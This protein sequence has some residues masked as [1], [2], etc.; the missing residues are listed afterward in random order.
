MSTSAPPHPAT[1]DEAEAGDHTTGSAKPHTLAQSLAHRV[2]AAAGWR[3]VG[4]APKE[5]KYVLIAAPHTTN[6]DLVLLLLASIEYGVWPNW[7]GK[8]TLFKPPFGPLMR[9]L[10]GIAVD[11]RARHNMVDHL[12]S[13]FREREKLIL[14]V[15]PEGTRSAA[16]H[17]K[18]GFYHI[19][20]AAKVPICLGYL[21]FPTKRAAL[22]PMMM[23]TGNI[24]ADMEVIRA[25]YAD[26]RGMYPQDQGPVRLASED[27][28]TN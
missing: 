5:A 4:E 3:I 27:P 6:W 9:A 20:V 16:P 13:L 22:G 25:F 1:R 23:P 15:P 19:A 7:V 26:K 11:R 17:W 2:L 18:S 28:K 12:A 8:H 10:G 21:D 24:K 14:A